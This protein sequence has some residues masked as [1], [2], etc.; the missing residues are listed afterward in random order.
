MDGELTHDQVEL[1]YHLLSE[2]GITYL[3]IGDNDHLKA[4]H[5][6]ILELNG[7]GAWRSLSVAE[8]AAIKPAHSR[9]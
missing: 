8:T 4:F 9:H 5:D 7:A 1:V 6:T 2:A 3:T